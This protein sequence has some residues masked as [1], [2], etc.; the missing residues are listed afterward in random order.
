M[1]VCFLRAEGVL[2]EFDHSLTIRHENEW[3]DSV[4]RGKVDSSRFD[5]SGSG[6]RSSPVKFCLK[7]PAEAHLETIVRDIL[8]LVDDPHQRRCRRLPEPSLRILGPLPEDIDLE[9]PARVLDQPSP[10]L[11]LLGQAPR[12]VLLLDL[13]ARQEQSRRLQVEPG[14]FR[15]LLHG[16]RE[17]VGVEVK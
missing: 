14:S 5:T 2:R 6:H 15:R 1:T 10:E 9:A 13:D 3:S 7:F 16:L 11:Q 12:D 8:Q 17:V 4:D